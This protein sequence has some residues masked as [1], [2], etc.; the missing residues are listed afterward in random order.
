MMPKQF[1]CDA[2]TVVTGVAVAG[3]QRL[4]LLPL[5]LWHQLLLL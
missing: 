4:E 3:E 1:A 5:L 2:D